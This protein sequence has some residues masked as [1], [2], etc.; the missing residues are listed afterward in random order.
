M[1]VRVGMKSRLNSAFNNAFNGATERVSSSW[2]RLRERE[3]RILW[4]SLTSLAAVCIAWALAEET[5]AST[6]SATDATSIAAST[7]QPNPAP[8]QFSDPN[9]FATLADRVVPSVV[10]ISSELQVEG[11]EQQVSPLEEEFEKFFHEFNGGREFPNGGRL[12][13]APRLPVT[14]LGSGVIV[15]TN[16]DHATIMTNHHVVANSQAIK[17]E[18]SPLTGHTQPVE[19]RVIA[20]DPVLDIAL[21]EVKML[22]G[23]KALPFGNSDKVKVGDYVMAVGNPFGQGHSV[24]HGIISAK[25][26]NGPVIGK[27]LQ[28]DALINRGNSG[29]PLVNLQGE[30]V[31]INEAIITAGIGFAIPANSIQPELAEL[32]KNGKIVR[33]QIGVHLTEVSPEAAAFVGGSIEAGQPVVNQVEP[34]STAAAAGLRPNDVIVSVDGKKIQ[35]SD[36]LR[37][38]ILSLPISKHI[39]LGVFRNGTLQNIDVEIGPPK[40]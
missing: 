5:L 17:V 11:R 33:G 2:D 31:G 9:L 29:G 23:L 32:R 28:T 35:D 19:G 37:S 1:A 6:A 38:A 18:F 24:T 27:F 22:D 30:I 8:A 36:A 10:N 34:G 39:G 13:P 26:R 15:D 25:N 4:M 21:I 3:S 7:P 20:A 16:P 40:A 14:S 12:R